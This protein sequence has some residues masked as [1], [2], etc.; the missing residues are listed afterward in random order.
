LKKM[1]GIIKGTYCWKRDINCN[2]LLT[3]ELVNTC[4]FH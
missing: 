4:K 3:K 1:N 2:H